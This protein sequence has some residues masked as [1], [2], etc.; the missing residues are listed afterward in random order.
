[1]LV[2]IAASGWLKIQDYVPYLHLTSS[3]YADPVLMGILQSALTPYNNDLYASSLARLPVLAIHGADDDNVPPRHSRQH[4]ALIQAWEGDCSHRKLVEVP[5][6]GHWWDDVLKQ[7][8]VYD[9]IANLSTGRDWLADR[10]RGFTLTT[11]NPEE[12]GSRSGVRIVELRQPGRLARLDVRSVEH[13]GQE[14]L[15]LQATNVK[16]V[17]FQ[18]QPAQE[19][20]QLV[21]N[22][23]AHGSGSDKWKHVAWDS[24]MTGTRQLGPMIRLL[25]TQGPITI[26]VDHAWARGMSI[27]L[28]YAHDLF[29]YHRL[30]VNVVNDTEAAAMLGTGGL[31]GNIVIIGRDDQNRFLRDIRQTSVASGLPV[32]FTNGSIAMG[33]R[34]IQDPGAGQSLLGLLMTADDKCQV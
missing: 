16:R 25:A 18:A 5:A 29:V 10:Q 17:S 1:M 19:L 8:E 9:F 24:D 23:I 27:A 2:V 21:E 7:P 20:A 32:S 13:E 28:R 31:A 15:D 14:R 3:H 30:A 4:V 12:S 22:N 26:V 6:K 11:A 33:G 34:R